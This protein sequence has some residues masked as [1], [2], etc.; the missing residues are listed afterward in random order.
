L[1][2]SAGWQTIRRDALFFMPHAVLRDRH[3]NHGI[4][5]QH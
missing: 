2:P 4:E 5:K 1:T 3:M